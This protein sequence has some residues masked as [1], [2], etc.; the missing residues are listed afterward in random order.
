MKFYHDRRKDTEFKCTRW[1]SA[2]LGSTREI[3]IRAKVQGAPILAPDTT[4]VFKT[5]RRQWHGSGEHEVLVIDTSMS[6]SDIPYGDYFS[7]EERWILTPLTSGTWTGCKLQC[8]A[9]VKFAKSTMFKGTISSRAKKDVKEAA[10]LYIQLATE[11]LQ[12]N[13]VTSE[14]PALP[15]PSESV[16]KVADAKQETSREQ[17]TGRNMPNHFLI[18]VWALTIVT[19]LAYIS[20]EIKALREIFNETLE[21]RRQQGS[22][23][24][25]IDSVP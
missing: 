21:L 20:F 23:I 5:Q 8:S 11:Y 14:S 1:K 17:S 2:E 12:E 19:L 13:G 7:I 3:S 10:E 4:R 15:N 6:M 9:H 16:A 25:S 18:Y 22:C 24:N